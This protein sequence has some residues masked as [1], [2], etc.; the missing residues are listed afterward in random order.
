[1]A[2]SSVVVLFRI[3]AIVTLLESGHSYNFLISHPF[4]GAS[5]VLTLRAVTENLLS[6]YISQSGETGCEKCFVDIFVTALYLLFFC[7]M[8]GDVFA[9][10]PLQ[11]LRK[12]QQNLVHILL[13]H[14][15]NPVKCFGKKK[16][17]L[18][19]RAKIRS[20]SLAV[21]WLP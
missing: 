6:R 13:L 2:V 5:H 10:Q 17:L 4:Y 19:T 3:V 18:S 12:C 15:C 9:Q 14:I 7:T 16:F 21:H 11:M 1:M 8:T 20:G